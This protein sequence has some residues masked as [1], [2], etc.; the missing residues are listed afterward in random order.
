MGRFS[1]EDSQRRD[2][3]QALTLWIVAEFIGLLF[4]PALEVI[5][6][7]SAVL[8]NWFVWSLF[9]GVGGVLLITLSSRWVELVNDRPGSKDSKMFAGLLAQAMGWVGLVG[10]LYPLIVSCTMFF[11][12]LNLK[13]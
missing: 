4:F 8:K 12:N 2:F 5:K 7:S 1:S 3:V 10:V 6:P 11:N 9:Y 13:I